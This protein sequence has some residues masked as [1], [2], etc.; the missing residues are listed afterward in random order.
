M[1]TKHFATTLLMVFTFAASA[2]AKVDGVY[3]MSTDG[4]SN[5]LVV[6][7]QVDGSVKLKIDSEPGAPICEGEFV[8]ENFLNNKGRF[9]DEL[10]EDR[11]VYRIAFTKKS[12]MIKI[13]AMNAPTPSCGH[14]GQLEGLYIK[15]HK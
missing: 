3:R 5:K 10:Q 2:Y 11:V 13:Q 12:A 9:V 15:T 4:L 1:K 14:Q 7:T 8:V 6:K